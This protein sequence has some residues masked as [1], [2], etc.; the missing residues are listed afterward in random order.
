MA[1]SRTSELLR[2]AGIG[3]IGEL[4]GAAGVADALRWFDRQRR[5]IDDKHLEVCRVPA[6]TF[7]E[8]QRALWMA[9]QFRQLGYAV[10]LDPAGN[11][12]AGNAGWNDATNLVALTAHLDTV[13]AP[14]RTEDIYIGA[15]HRF[16][17]PGVA[18]NGAGLAALL[19]IA[20]SLRANPIPTDPP[21]LIFVANVGEEGEG[22]LSGMRYLCRPSGLADRVQAFLVLDG[23]STD[24]ITAR[25]VASR[26]FEVSISG[27][28]GHSWSDFGAANPVHALSRAITLFA[29][30]CANGIFNASS[31]ADSRVAFNFGTF[32]GGTSVNAIPALARAK[33][34]LRA[35]DPDRIRE[36]AGILTSAVQRALEIEH[37]RPSPTRLSAKIREIGSRPGGQLPEDSPVLISLRAVD[38]YLGIRSYPDSASTDANIP[39]SLG[40]EAVSIG[41]GGHGGGTHTPAEWY[42]PV[43]RELGLARILLTLCLLARA[44]EPR[45]AAKIP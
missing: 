32:D 20:A 13:L 9:D 16:H 4:A 42:D 25:A 17:G 7:Q 40:R 18:D 44:A 26:R 22:N 39:L 38:D 30:T 2:K 36:M 33:V 10:E 12:L 1:V 29:D 45:A 37:S 19:A 24:R 28:G 6:P 5:W 14:R 34:D 8:G 3:S 35:E 43:G 23:P 41:A 15:D 31:R 21:R 11:V 27:P